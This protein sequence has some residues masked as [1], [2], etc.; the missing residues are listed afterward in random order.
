M[1]CF[2]ALVD[3]WISHPPSGPTTAEEN[4][5][6]FLMIH[7]RGRWVRQWWRQIQCWILDPAVLVLNPAMVMLYPEVLSPDPT[8]LATHPSAMDAETSVANK[9]CNEMDK[10][11]IPVWSH[12]MSSE[13]SYHGS[14]S[15]GLISLSH[16]C[17]VIC[18]VFGRASW[19]AQFWVPPENFRIEP[20]SID[21]PITERVWFWNA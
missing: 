4:Q 5:T 16:P 6:L 15:A 3:H 2:Q 11:F 14:T 7:W 1:N 21:L 20:R 13:P 17:S 19:F 10:H 18:L 12:R 9:I 8:G